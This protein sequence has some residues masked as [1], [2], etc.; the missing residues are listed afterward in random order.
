MGMHDRLT[1]TTSPWTPGFSGA[2][3]TELG[4]MTEIANLGLEENM[5]TGTNEWTLPGT[6]H[7]GI[8]SLLPHVLLLRSIMFALS[9]AQERFQLS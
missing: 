1:K 2:I 7:T 3:P 9:I 8:I 6:C 4:L 5:L